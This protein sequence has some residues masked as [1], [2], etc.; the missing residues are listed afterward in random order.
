MLLIVTF[1][2]SCHLL[3]ILAKYICA[4]LLDSVFG[5]LKAGKYVL[6]QMKY[7]CITAR[8]KDLRADCLTLVR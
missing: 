8:E 7:S 4:M 2:L 5:W 3:S 6:G 1:Y